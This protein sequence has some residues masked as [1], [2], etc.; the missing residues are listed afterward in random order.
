MTDPVP[1]REREFDDWYRDRHLPDVLGL[2]GFAAAQR[3]AFA[4]VGRWLEAPHRHLALYEV[5]GDLDAAAGALE[6]ALDASR[7]AERAGLPPRMSSSSAL[8]P[9]RSAWWFSAIDERQLA[10]G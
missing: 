8:A 6:R 5:E 3:F 7:R 9:A 1:G 4:P 10:A 2:E